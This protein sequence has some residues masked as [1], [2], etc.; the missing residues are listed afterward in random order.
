M[1]TVDALPPKAGVGL[2]TEHFQE[3]LDTQPHIAWFEL[4]PEN[5]MCAGGLAHRYLTKIRE[6]YPLSMHGVGLSLG[7][8]EGL[9]ETHLAKL[10]NLIA[11]YEPCQFSEHIAWCRRG[12]HYSNDLLPLPYTQESLDVLCA[13]IEKTQ[14][15]LARS[16]LVENPSTYID[17]TQ[18][19]YS[20]PEFM[21]EVCKRTG[22]GVVLDINN[23]YVSATNHDFDP[24]AYLDAIDLS[25]IGEI[26]LAGHSSTQL[27]DQTLVLIDDH[28]SAIKDA[29][30]D[31][32]KYFLS[33]STEP[34]PALVEW[35]T[36]VPSL[37]TLL[38]E[39]KK[40]QSHMDTR[41]EER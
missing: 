6:R 38:I 28:G 23:V 21:N 29:V 3:I 13:N 1:K 12:N 39:A 9:S 22:C 5:Y 31:L 41:N 18:A 36:N 8:V 20:E 25:N 11:R 14:D 35:D 16:I 34:T 17:F 10:K 4:H 40:A 15:Y 7:S 30:W 32:Y 27:K 26:H 19:E 24:H 37:T 33:I 2:K